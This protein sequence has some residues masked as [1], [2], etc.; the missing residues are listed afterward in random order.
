[1]L[2]A[3][4]D[5]KPELR[6]G[7]RTGLF[8]RQAQKDSARNEAAKSPSKYPTLLAGV[9]WW[10]PVTTGPSVFSAQRLTGQP[11]LMGRVDQLV[12]ELQTLAR[13]TGLANAEDL[14]RIRKQGPP[15]ADDD[16]DTAGRFG[17]AVFQ[18]LALTAQRERQPLLLDY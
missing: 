6:P 1:V 17:L 9:E 13:Q 15:A 18:S 5:E 16:V 7:R 2:L 12:I 14:E 10:L 3:A 4:Y 11:T 8:A